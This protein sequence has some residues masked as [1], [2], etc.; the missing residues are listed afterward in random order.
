MR[1]RA[2]RAS[3]RRSRLDDLAMRGDILVHLSL[4]SMFEECPPLRA[5]CRVL[6]RAGTRPPDARPA[7]ATLVEIA[8][9]RGASRRGDR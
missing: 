9:R 1:S 4:A 8:S 5:L 3:T 6:L 2:G 7:A